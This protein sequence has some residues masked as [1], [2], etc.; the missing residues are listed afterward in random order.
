MPR[1][2]VAAVAL[3]G[4]LWSGSAEAHVVATPAFLPSGSSESITFTVPNERDDPMTAFTL[5]AQDGVAIE[6]AHAVAGWNE[7]LEDSTATWTGGSLASDQEASF[8]VDL[9]ADREPGVVEL[10]AAQRYPYGA[11]VTWP[12]PL[13]ITPADETP[14]Q[15]L[16]LAAVVGLIGVLAVVAVVMLARR[17]RPA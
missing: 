1:P 17:R 3:I 5:T 16:V 11:V 15:N 13:T 6:H 7:S 8:G 9:A 14:S 4:F 2:L 10:Q 12:V